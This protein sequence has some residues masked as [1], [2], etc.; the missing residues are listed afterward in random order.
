VELM[1]EFYKKHRPQSFKEVVGQKSQ[2]TQLVNMAKSKEGLPHF[3]LLTGPSG[4]GKTTIARIIKKAMQ[5]S[6]VDYVEMNGSSNRGIDDIRKI[7]KR[8]HCS[9]VAGKVRIWVVD[10]AHALTPDAQN[11]ILKMLEDT[12]QHVY[13][14]F[15]TTDPQKL[16]RT[17]RTRA[18][19]IKCDPVDAED[20]EELL[21]RVGKA[22]GIILSPEVLQK[23]IYMAEGSPRQALVLLNSLVGQPDSE[24][25]LAALVEND[26]SENAKSIARALLDTSTTWNQMSQLIK[27]CDDD[28]EKIRRCV[29]GYMQSVLLRGRYNEQARIVLEEFR[30]PLYDIGKP[31]LTLACANLV[32]G[33]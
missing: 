32:G 26:I 14:I 16:K 3:L 18:T 27:A 20:M 10:E 19:E 4:C 1:T 22:E 11:C 21:T 17:I 23:L 24:S 29:L 30:D 31:G 8:L 9:P 5:C 25:Q 13:F 28:P 12:P 2:L 15:C 6:D 7:E 33:K